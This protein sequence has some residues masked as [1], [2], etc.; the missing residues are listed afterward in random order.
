MK[1]FAVVAHDYT[2][3]EDINRRL[4]AREAHLEGIRKL[5][6]NANFISGGAM[7]NEAGK[8]IGSNAHFQFATRQDFD[9]WLASEPYM[10][11]R[12]W[13]KVDVKEIK[14]FDPNG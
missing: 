11:E 5:A 10:T 4:A 8:M 12:V 2:D 9:A 3:D 14:L 13:E 6:K 7:L 1:Q